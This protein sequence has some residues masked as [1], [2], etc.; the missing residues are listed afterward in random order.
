MILH[1]DKGRYFEGW[2]II[3]R[4]F[5]YDGSGTEKLVWAPM[6]VKNFLTTQNTHEATKEDL[7]RLIQL[8]FSV[9]EV[10][11]ANLN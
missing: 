10:K 6:D 4:I 8:L 3:N 11:R 2:Y 1:R 7:E 5:F 9:R